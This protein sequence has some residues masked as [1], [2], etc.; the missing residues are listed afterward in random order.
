[1]TVDRGADL[2]PLS[3]YPHEEEILFAP[4]SS[5]EL[6]STHVENSVLIVRVNLNINLTALTIE[7]VV[8][9]MKYSHRD[10]LRLIRVQED[11]HGVFSA[12]ELQVLT[13]LDEEAAAQ[14]P[15]WFNKPSN[16]LLATERALKTVTKLRVIM[17]VGA[18]RHASGPHLP[19]RPGNDNERGRG[20]M[21]FS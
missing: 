3:Q 4:L 6:Q 12:E 5:L 14:D 21:Q 7:K 19:V 11:N 9:K 2:S 10:L 15:K 20:C 18:H 8:G 1:M 13:G 16:Y 17:Q